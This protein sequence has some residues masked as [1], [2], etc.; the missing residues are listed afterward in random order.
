MGFPPWPLRLSL[1][2]LVDSTS[3]ES[4]ILTPILVWTP[5]RHRHVRHTNPNFN[6]F[7]HQASM[8]LDYRRSQPP[9][10]FFK[11]TFILLACWKVKIFISTFL[12][13]FPFIHPPFNQ[14]YWQQE[15]LFHYFLN[16][17]QFYLL[18]KLNS[19]KY[20]SVSFFLEKLAN[21]PLHLVVLLKMKYFCFQER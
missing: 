2:N 19:I 20:N 17:K 10:H 8:S 15:N 3:E 9:S 12:L 1:I 5:D 14:Q 4:T 13:S 6:S 16:T 11:F 21:K 18:T 7:Q